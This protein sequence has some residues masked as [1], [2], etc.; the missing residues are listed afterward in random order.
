MMNGSGRG[1]T[2][3]KEARDCDREGDAADEASEDLSDSFLSPHWRIFNPV[4]RG[5]VTGQG[6]DQLR[7]PL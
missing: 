2:E 7:A 4:K 1:G 5:A 3:P 6:E